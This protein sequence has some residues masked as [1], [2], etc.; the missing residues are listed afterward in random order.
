MI[1]QLKVTHD[2]AVKNRTAAVVTLKAMLI[3]PPHR[4]AAVVQF[5]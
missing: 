1:R 3:Q 4:V 2:T 5:P